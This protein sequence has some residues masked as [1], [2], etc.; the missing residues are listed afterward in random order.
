MHGAAIRRADTDSVDLE[1]EKI[2]S[3]QQCVELRVPGGLSPVDTI[4]GFDKVSSATGSFYRMSAGAITIII[5]SRN[6]DPQPGGAHGNWSNRGEA[7][8]H[9]VRFSVTC[10]TQ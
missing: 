4:A 7:G 1:T 9:C 3:D 10:S 5:H 2:T 6:G 8:A